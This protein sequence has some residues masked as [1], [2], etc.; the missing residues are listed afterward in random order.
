MNGLNQLRGSR[1]DRAHFKLN[2]GAKLGS[3]GPSMAEE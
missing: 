1:L 3:T 2:R